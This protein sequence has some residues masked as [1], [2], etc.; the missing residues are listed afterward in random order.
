MPKRKKRFLKRL[1]KEERGQSMVSYAVIT[2]AILG[3]LL[4][5]SMVILPRM[6]SALDNFTASLYFGINAPFP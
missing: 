6:L 5:M 2:A 1:L 3:G 4:T